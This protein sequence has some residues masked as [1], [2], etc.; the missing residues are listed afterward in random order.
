[1]SLFPEELSFWG[2][3]FMQRIAPSHETVV[4]TRLPSSAYLC[5][6][7]TLS[8]LVSPLVSQIVSHLSPTCLPLVSL[9]AFCVLALARSDLVSACLPRL[10]PPLV[11]VL[12]LGDSK[13]YL[14]RATFAFH[15]AFL[16][17]WVNYSMTWITSLRQ[18]LTLAG[19][20]IGCQGLQCLAIC[21]LT[22]TNCF[23]LMCGSAV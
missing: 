8:R 7:R 23:K 1:M 18:D 20:L 5:L 13:T 3:L 19:Y 22:E 21:D 17:L 10:N 4:P 14:V 9:P 2:S 11:S 6:A 16:A 12:V 15:D